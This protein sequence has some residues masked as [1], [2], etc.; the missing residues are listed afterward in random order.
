MRCVSVGKIIK[1]FICSYCVY[2]GQLRGDGIKHGHGVYTYAS[3]NKY[4][5]QWENDQ[6][7]GRGEETFGDDA[8]YIGEYRDDKC[9]G[10]GTNT[11]ANG[12]TYVGEF[13]HDLYHGQGTLTAADGTVL[14]AGQFDKDCPRRA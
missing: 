4:V 3:G 9:H 2:I 12:E 1:Y 14:H 11:K 7:N 8:T 10:W 13:A 5:G 6:R